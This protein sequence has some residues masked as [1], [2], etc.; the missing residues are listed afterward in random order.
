MEELALFF[1]EG[2]LFMYLIL[3]VLV[4]GMAI[5]IERVYALIIKYNVDGRALWV[6][7]SGFIREGD[8]AGAGALCEGSHVPLMRVLDA[9][10]SA[11]D[12]SEREIQDAIDEVTLELMPVI[13]K[14]TSYLQTLANVA[15]LLGLL[16]TISGLIQAF[17]AVGKADPSQKAALLAGGISIALYTTAFGLIVAIPMLTVYTILQARTH[18]IIDEIDEFSVKFINLLRRKKSG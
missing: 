11:A 7:V 12:R 14:R 15:T 2:G 6:K 10:I 5:T 9:G 8:M 17:T 18:K 1:R 4:I 13:D 16:G 3:A